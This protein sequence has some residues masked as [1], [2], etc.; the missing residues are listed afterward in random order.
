MGL[1]LTLR[2][3]LF[4]HVNLVSFKNTFALFDLFE[5]NS[6]LPLGVRTLQ[7]SMDLY[8]YM[9]DEKD[10]E[11]V[12]EDRD[13][14]KFWELWAVWH[15]QM[16]NIH[17]LTICFSHNDEDFLDRLMEKAEL[18]QMGSLEKLHLRASPEEYLPSEVEDTAVADW[19]PWDSPTWVSAIARLGNLHHLILSTPYLPFWPP[20]SDEVNTLHSRWFAE[21]PP[22][23][24]LITFV[25]HCGWADDSARLE[26][27][28]EE[29]DTP[30]GLVG[31]HETRNPSFP[32]TL[33]MAG[34]GY[35]P[36]LVWT[37]DAATNTWVEDGDP[38]CGFG[39]H[40]YFDELRGDPTSVVKPRVYGYE[41]ALF[42]SG[43]VVGQAK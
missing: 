34:D 5:Q 40:L 31:F 42:Q 37:R 36:T 30:K 1:D 13:V 35:T 4:R 28:D 16:P 41:G 3:L 9:A 15:R 38:Y 7:I 24:K 21:L 25:L 27:F 17:T 26:A 14:T 39:E 33:C 20:S 11:A 2:P 18:D 32:P 6:K 29:N 22:S 12:V 8:P 23:A 19:G 10:K 43:E